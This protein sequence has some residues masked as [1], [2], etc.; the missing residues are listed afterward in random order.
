MVISSWTADDLIN[1]IRIISA[2]SAPNLLHLLKPLSFLFGRKGTKFWFLSFHK[3]LLPFRHVIRTAQRLQGFLSGPKRS[4]I[5]NLLYFYLN[6]AKCYH[7]LSIFIL[8]LSISLLLFRSHTT[9]CIGGHIS[10]C[11]QA[12][13]YSLGCLGSF[14][15]T[16][17]LSGESSGSQVF[18]TLEPTSSR[19]W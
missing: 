10:L 17:R 1:T 2:F 18:L 13:S 3:N 14:L 8:L 16:S 19:F 7:R 4:K 5:I 12:I 11:H 9:S 6:Y 15:T